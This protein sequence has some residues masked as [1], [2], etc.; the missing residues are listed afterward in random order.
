[1]TMQ[2]ALF[3]F[4]LLLASACDSAPTPAPCH[5]I[6]D[7]GCPVD[8]GAN[9]CQDPSCD[10]V[11]ACVDGAW[12]L[13]QTCPPRPHEAGVN[14]VDASDAGS[15]FDANID[16]PPGAW[17]GPGCLD[18]QMPDCP[19]GE[20]LACVQQ[21]DC[22]GCT[23]LWACDDGGWTLWGECADGGIVLSP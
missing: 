13:E 4:F 22:C 23:D 18:L 20:G 2:T 12:Q 10:A 8:N 5:E 14:G 6:P 7:G 16:A 17:G 15:T 9:V 1:M 3:G 21:P 11:Y 19:A